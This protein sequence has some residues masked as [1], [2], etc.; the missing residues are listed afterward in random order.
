MRKIGTILLCLALSFALAYAGTVKDSPQTTAPCAQGDMTITA[1][2]PNDVGFENQWKY[3]ISGSWDTGVANALSHISFLFAL[4][5]ELKGPAIDEPALVK[6]LEHFCHDGVKLLVGNLA[7]AAPDDASLWVDE[8]QCRP[9]T[10]RVLLPDLEDLIVY[11]RMLD[12][13]PEDGLA[14]ILGGLLGVELGRVHADD[15]QLAGIFAFQFP[16]LRK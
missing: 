12:P 8:H 3:T 10:H 11:D 16:Q 2:F 15:R 9:R 4:R 14:D 13:V 5:P 1:T 7:L 6:L